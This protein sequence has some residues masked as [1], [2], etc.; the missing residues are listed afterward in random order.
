MVDATNKRQKV[1][2]MGAV[3]H[4]GPLLYFMGHLRE[5]RGDEGCV[6]GL[7]QRWPGASQD[8]PEA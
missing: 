8:S 2:V 6:M 5:A 3:G 7:F 1:I 4:S